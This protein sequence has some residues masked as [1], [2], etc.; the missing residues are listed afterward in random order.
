MTRNEGDAGTSV[1]TFAVTTTQ[2]P[3]LG[4]PAQSVSF[5][6]VNSTATAG[7]DY[8]GT[9]GQITFSSTSPA[10]QQVNVTVNGDT[11]FE[12]NEVFIVRLSNPVNAQ[13]IEPDGIGTIFNDDV[14]PNFSVNSISMN[15]GNSG[16][17]AFTFTF[18][19]SG[20]PTSFSSVLTYATANGTATAPGDYAAVTGGVTF[21]PNETSKSVT[22]S[23]VGDTVVEPNETFTMN[24]TSITNGVIAAAAGTG[25]IINDDGAAVVVEGDV[26]DAAGN[27]SGGDGVLANDVSVL[28]LFVL[29][30]QVPVTTPNQFQR[31]D[32]NGNCGDGAVNAGDVTV[33]RLMVLGIVTPVPACGP[34]APLI[35]RPSERSSS[36]FFGLER[37]P[38]F[39]VLVEPRL[40]RPL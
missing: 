22:V 16:T 33:V 13:I 1:F 8:S 4:A 10:L 30:L 24:I 25:T 31:A 39:S 23:V 6:T 26:V 18:T 37:S 38:V 29:G 21:A 9:S 27:P 2:L 19:R 36:Q 34:T 20:N 32:I 11:T 35:A 28:R 17:T 12:P 5:A 7:S 3:A 14:E 15:E 40:E